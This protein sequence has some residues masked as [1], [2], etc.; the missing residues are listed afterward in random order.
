M[1][2]SSI[3]PQDEIEVELLH[4]KTQEPLG[5]F[6]TLAGPSHPEVSAK[7][8]NILDRSRGK[9][10]TSEQDERDGLEL[11]CTRILGWRGFKKEGQEL[12][13]SKSNVQELLSDRKN[14]WIRRQI[15]EKLDDQANFFN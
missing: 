7:I 10:T 6:V 13:F 3:I 4:P 12:A 1:D 14:F 2:I 9:K 8:R 15:M 5:A 11:L